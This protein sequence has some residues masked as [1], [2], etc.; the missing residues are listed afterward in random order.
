MPYISRL[1]RTP[2]TKYIRAIAHEL[3][4]RGNTAGDLNYV[5]TAL[6]N[7]W[8]LGLPLS[9]RQLNIVSGTLHDVQDE[10]DRTVKHPYE[11]YK[12]AVNG[13]V[14]D[15]RLIT[16]SIGKPS[17]TGGSHGNTN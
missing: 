7:E 17:S 13:G 9:Y 12:R 6:L 16:D 14:Y 3:L 15:E 10:F 8:L 2:Y 11:D 4:V 5:F 1:E